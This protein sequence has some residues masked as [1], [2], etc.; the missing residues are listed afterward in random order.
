MSSDG[1]S[2]EEFPSGIADSI[3]LGSGS[4]V[5]ASARLLDDL[6][7]SS[8]KDR[9]L[10]SIELLVL[11]GV[12]SDD[13]EWSLEKDQEAIFAA[14][15]ALVVLFFL[16]VGA[17]RGLCFRVEGVDAGD[18]L[19]LVSPASLSLHRD[20][21]SFLTGLVKD[22]IPPPKSLMRDVSSL[23]YNTELEAPDSDS[24]SPKILSGLS[25]A[26]LITFLLMTFLAS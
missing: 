20:S 8:S 25:A 26:V 15:N 3:A 18:L 19:F 4:P 24:I 17:S 16:A 9:K 22:A 10:L 2:S 7:F 13:A 5:F 12:A 1:T 11:T 6:S 14:R 23:S 21:K